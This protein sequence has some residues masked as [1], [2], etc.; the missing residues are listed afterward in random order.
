FKPAGAITSKKCTNPLFCEFAQP[1][2]PV[3]RPQRDLA[4]A[5]QADMFAAGGGVQRAVVSVCDFVFKCDGAA[6]Y[7]CHPAAHSDP[8]AVTRGGT[9]ANGNIGHAHEVAGTLEF[10]VIVAH[11]AGKVRT[12]LFHPD[13]VRGVVDYALRVGFGVTNIKFGCGDKTIR[14]V[15]HAVSV[16]STAAGAFPERRGSP[17]SRLRSPGFRAARLLR[18]SGRRRR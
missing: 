2:S 11:D 7:L 5:G 3:L 17:R 10:G 12:R 18:G 15:R 1:L 14:A 16:L 13:N 6:F 9:V 4:V 8:I